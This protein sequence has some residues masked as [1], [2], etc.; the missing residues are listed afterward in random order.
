MLDF[1]DGGG[2]GGGGGIYTNP[3]EELMSEHM[4]GQHE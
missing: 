4:A 3:P 2:G 1:S